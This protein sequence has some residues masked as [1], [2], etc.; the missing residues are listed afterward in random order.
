MSITIAK[1]QWEYN[2]GGKR[3]FSY[4]VPQ[5]SK[6]H[7]I[8]QTSG[9]SKKNPDLLR[10]KMVDPIVF[11]F[12]GQKFYINYSRSN[13]L[14]TI[15]EKN[16]QLPSVAYVWVSVIIRYMTTNYEHWPSAD[17][18]PEHH[19]CPFCQRKFMGLTN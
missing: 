5:D 8:G 6:F 3:F 14:E 13:D 11:H 9:V 16:P 17:D 2:T 15:K 4:R 19:T 10:Q 12:N 18:S 1:D 7:A